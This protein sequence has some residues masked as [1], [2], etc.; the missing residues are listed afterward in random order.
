[1]MDLR[2]TIEDFNRLHECATRWHSS[3]SDIVRRAE[4]KWDRLGIKLPVELF[5][6]TE[7]STL[8]LSIKIRKY[9]TTK[10]PEELRQIITWY[11]NDQEGKE[12]PS[13]PIKAEKLPFG[14]RIISHK[15][16]ERGMK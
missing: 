13:T 9:E 12:R 15:Q 4:K 1:M 5:K 2:L 10:Q 7:C 14:T 16:Y 3:K 11:L 8:K 6:K